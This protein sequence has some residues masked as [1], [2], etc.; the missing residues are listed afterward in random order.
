[1]TV[2]DPPRARPRLPEPTRTRWQPLRAGFVDLFHYD[3][4]EFWFRDGHLLLRGNNGTGKSKV[5]ALLLPFLLDGET[6]SHR[7]EPDG[8]PGKRM[9]WNLLLGGRHPAPERTGYTWC[10]FGRLLPDGSETHLTV[11]CGMKAVAGRTGVTTWFFVT[12]QRV[13]EDLQLITPSRTALTRQGLVEAVEAVEGPGRGK[14]HDQASRHRRA[15][16]EALFDLS[17]E[18]YDALLSLLI[19]LRQPQLSKR[20]DEATLSRALTEALPPLDGAVLADVAEAFRSLEEERSAVSGFREARDAAARRPAS[21]RRGR[22]RGRCR[23]RPEPREAQSRYEETGRRLGQARAAAQEAREAQAANQSAASECES[24]TAHIQAQVEVLRDRPEWRDADRLAEAERRARADADRADDARAEQERSI[25]ALG[26]QRGRQQAAQR[27]A[28]VAEDELAAASAAADAAARA[29]SLPAVT[30]LLRAP[31]A[32]KR[33]AAEAARQR[34]A[35]QHVQTLVDAASRAETAA[36]DA[37]GRLDEAAADVEAAAGAEETARRVADTAATGLLDATEAALDAALEL[38]LPD[39]ED[40]T[41]ALAGW[42]ETLDGPNPVTAAAARVARAHHTELTA[43]DL[44]LA[45]EA[46]AVTADRERLADERTRLESGASPTPPPSPTRDRDS[47]RGRDGAPL[48]QLID[49][50]DH[51]DPPG[52]AG[53]E[54]AL[55]AGG[56]LDAWVTPDGSLLD[57]DDAVVTPGAPVDA[58]LAAALRPAVDRGDAQAAAVPDGAVARVLAGIG[59][60]A[61]TADTWVEPDGRF[62]VGVLEGRWHK[63]AAEYLGSGARA[64]AR[65]ARLA[66]LAVEIAALDARLEELRTGREDIVR[67]QRRLDRDVASLPPDAALRDALAAVAAR[68]D[69]RERAVGR[70]DERA[71]AL[72][73]ARATTSAATAER[74]RAADDLGLPRT[75]PE[76]TTLLAAIG[77]YDVAL[78]ALWPARGRRDRAADNVA[79]AEADVHAA[80][81]LVG[82]RGERAVVAAAAARDSAAVSAALLAAIGPPVA[83][84]QAQLAA[85]RERLAELKRDAERLRAEGVDAAKAVGDA[86]G[87]EAELARSLDEHAEARGAA[88]TRLRRFVRS[89]LLALAL[90]DQSTPDPESDWAP[91]PAV[92]LARAVNEALGDVDDTDDVWQRRTRAVAEALPTLQEVLSRSGNSAASWATDAGVVVTAAWRGRE[93]G[94]ADLVRDLE[95]E[96][97]ERDRLLSAREQEVLERHLVS[98]IAVRVQELTR[99]AE[100]SVHRMNVELAARPTSTG[101]QLRFQWV[102]DVDGPAGLAEARSRL[103]RQTS[104]A[105]SED[106][107]RAVGTFLRAEVERVRAEDEGGTWLEH[108]TAALDYRRWHRFAIERRQDGRWR[109]ATGPASGGERVLAATVPLFAA[110]ASHYASAGNPHAPRLVLLDEAFAGVDDDSRA[111]CLGLLAEFDLDYVLTS[112]REWGCY[113]TVPGLA[114]AQLSR[115]DEIDAVLVTHWEWDGRRRA[116]LDLPRQEPSR[117]S[118]PREVPPGDGTEPPGLWDPTE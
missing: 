89:G 115:S 96:L 55:Q 13:G 36:L 54:A 100:A 5:L 56:L 19:S 113:P 73:A 64:A 58:P 68:A 97:A 41:A 16:N 39:R 90:P 34:R 28:A 8:D 74:D 117:E 23:G 17:Q 35:V 40:A 14:V 87:R 76:L 95:A 52:R 47:R 63:P 106:D 92:L 7:V 112:E 88:V 38:S 107:R 70:R 62:R 4:E 83:E 44:R 51:V 78:A 102:P 105:W 46:D 6:S 116:L 32:Q 104:D 26:D 118:P 109:P 111:K 101:M 29:A 11:G 15:V 91:T 10:E 103:L 86:E 45:A 65:R 94:L 12:D 49:F 72:E 43:A 57:A 69:A 110:A 93:T 66:Q 37:E 30:P 33:A 75:G 82:D 27:E 79:T 25:A 3:V 77:R 84:L 99:E 50:H 71:R 80:E 18:R 67:R 108:L 61:A 53:L 114:I 85:A 2:L 22:T 1:M 9:E 59:L 60:G 81:L 42:I 48:W 24:V 98:D 20:P 21:P 31:D